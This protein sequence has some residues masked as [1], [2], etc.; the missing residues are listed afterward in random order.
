M[1]VEKILIVDDELLIRNFLKETLTRKAYDVMTAENGTKALAIL[2]EQSFDLVITDMKM[3]DMTG[4][5]ILRKVKEL[6]PSTLVI[7]ITAF[8]SIE[9][10]VEAMRIGAFNYLIKP[11]SPDTIEAVI[12]K[13]NELSALVA[14]N[15]YLRAAQSSRSIGKVIAESPA[16]QKIMQD[17]KRIAKSSA[18]VFINGESG[19]GKE[20]FAHAI[21]YHSNR[22]SN[23]FIRVNCAAVPDALV[24]SEFFGHEK[25]AFTGANLK[26]LGRFELAD[27]GSLLLD[28]VTEIPISL[29]P[30]LLRAIQEQEFE[31]V[32]GSKL[33]EVDVR[34]IATSNRN[35]KQAIQE[36]IF[37]EDLYYRLN[38]VPINLPALRDRRED[39]IPL[40][41]YFIEKMGLENHKK[42]KKLS[43][44]A[45]KKMLDYH[46]P[47]NIRE[48]ANIIERAIVM[49]YADIIEP[50]HLY[51]EEEKP[52]EDRLS[53][54][55]LTL[56]EMEKKLIIETLSQQNNNRTKTAE[57]LGISIRT[58]RNKLSE[59]ALISPEECA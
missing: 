58:L 49:D 57:M 54:A 35:M 31:R 18:S 23:P 53:L 51:L 20:V 16:M 10:A 32:G 36:K 38:V 39:I 12:E 19:T 11:F 37:R 47:G 7:V 40:A 56:Q 24:E 5:D 3:P 17:I 14:E 1:A 43:P 30:K 55:G 15:N 2:K 21:H 50:D 25:G 22:A 46:W 59:Y 26:R 45:A 29:Q 44:L 33:V 42:K 48:L 6:Y 27:K 52:A 4:L 13:G 9:N 28:E 41:E 34:F 8:G